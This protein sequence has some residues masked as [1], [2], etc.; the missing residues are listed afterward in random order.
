MNYRRIGIAFCIELIE[1]AQVL[2][3]ILRRFFDVVPVCCKIGGIPL[4]ELAAVPAEDAGLRS[5]ESVVCNPRGQ[6]EVLNQRETD[7]NII[8]G[9]CVGADSLFARESRAPVTTLFVKDRSLANNPI[10]ALYSDYYVRESI[11]PQP[12]KGRGTAR[13]SAHPGKSNQIHEPPREHKGKEE[14]H[15]RY[16]D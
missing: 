1:P 10:G 13:E 16:Y 8:V 3:T 2:T 12:G 7:I 15:D 14:E 5:A 6:A 11:T 4:H 9:L